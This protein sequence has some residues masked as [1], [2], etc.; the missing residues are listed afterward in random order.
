MRWAASD[1][2]SAATE[3]RS[4]EPAA[5]AFAAG[6]AIL[7]AAER[8]DAGDRAGAQ[9]ILDERADLLRRAAQALD[10]P[11]LAED[12]ARLARLATAVGGGAES[13]RDPLPL[14]VMLRG[15]GYGYL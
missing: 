11:R 12:G 8:V 5:Q 15:A 2:E 10:Q 14:V 7:A 9:Q 1:A 4:I 13:V 6:E 3:D